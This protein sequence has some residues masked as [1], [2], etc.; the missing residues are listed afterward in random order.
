MDDVN[1]PSLWKAV[2]RADERRKTVFLIEKSWPA[3]FSNSALLKSDQ[4]GVSEEI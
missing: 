4:V 1:L 3:F 2:S